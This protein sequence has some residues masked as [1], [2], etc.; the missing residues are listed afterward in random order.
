MLLARA[1]VLEPD[2]LKWIPVGQT[3]DFGHDVF[4][5]LLAAATRVAGYIIKDN[6][7]D[8]GLPEKYEQ[9]NRLASRRIGSASLSNPLVAEGVA[10]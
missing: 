7:I 4:P 6:L 1:L 8:I 9:A 5:A 10:W 2:V 3:W